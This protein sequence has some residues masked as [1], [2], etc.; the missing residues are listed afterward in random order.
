M[1]HHLILLNDEA[2]LHCEKGKL[3]SGPNRIAIDVLG[4]VQCFS[5]RA[6]W[7]Q[8]ALE[9]VS[10]QCP[11]VL[12]RWNKEAGKWATCSVTPRTRYVQPAA[13]QSLCRLSEKQA[14]RFASDLIFAKVCNQHTLLRSYDP[15]LPPAPALRETSFS[16]ILRLESKYARFFWPRYFQ[17]ASSDLFAREKRQ[18]KTPLNVAL[19]Y[20]Y[21]FLYHAIE[22]QCLASGL[23]AGIGLI[24]RLRRNRPSLVCDLIE[25]FRCCVEL[26][27]IRHLDEIHDKKMLAARFAEMME[28]RFHHKANNFRLRTIIRIVIESFVR[29]LTEKSTF[30]PFLLHA[31]DA[32]V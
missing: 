22:W 30:S 16:R 27:V 7:S 28:E 1:I 8:V 21:G 10:A 5:S 32:C 4:S 20:G 3:I 23:D 15:L 31:R 12:A 14:T 18:A 9:A 2:D 25:Q 19:N 29:A 26:T 11:L 17:A 24:H 13:L 6:R